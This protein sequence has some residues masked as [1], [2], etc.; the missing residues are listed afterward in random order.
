MHMNYA[1]A[2]CTY[3]IP[4]APCYMP[5]APCHRYD[6]L[7]VFAF[8]KAKC[9]SLA[10]QMGPLHLNSADEEAMVENIF[11]NA[12]ETLSEDDQ[13]LP[14]VTQLLPMLKRGVAVRPP[15]PPT[16]PTSYFSRPTSYFLLPTSYFLRSLRLL[17]PTCRHPPRSITRACY[18]SS[19]SSWRSSSRCEQIPNRA[20]MTLPMSTSR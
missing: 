10:A 2:L 5:H 4:H 9:E 15:A 7:I 11:T 18:L 8:G 3:P 6:P 16:L 19:R 14:Q 20:Q 12:I 13:S 17:M 1:Y